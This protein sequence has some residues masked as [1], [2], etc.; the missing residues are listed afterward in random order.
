[1]GAKKVMV[2]GASGFL[3]TSLCPR[4][5][6][7]G[8]EVH[9]VSRCS[10]NDST[11]YIRWWQG[12][13]TDSAVARRLFSKIK[14]DIVF[15]FS[16]MATGRPDAKLVLPTFHSLLTSTVNLLTAAYEVGCERFVLAGSCTES[17]SDDAPPSSPYA[18]AKSASSMYARMFHSLYGVPVVIARIFVT[19]G[20]GQSRDKLIPY[21]VGSFLQGRPPKLA[22]GK[23][24]LDWIYIDDVV[25][26]LV[27]ASSA[28]GLEG[29]TV[30]LGSGTLVATEKV[31]EQTARVIG[32]KTE[33]LF[34]A[35]PDRPLKCCGSANIEQTKAVLGWSPAVSL[36]EGLRRTVSWYRNH[37]S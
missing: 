27:A 35:L 18:A 26:G 16:G 29:R 6:K 3:G 15:H 1:M 7:A 31:V 24:R 10:R 2:T 32:T 28:P 12:E 5:G 20:A 21:V 14:P 23:E 8:A 17:P 13:L 25:E 30:D 33:P 19:Y 9:G 34:G 22:S 4:L 36:D 11:G 37:S